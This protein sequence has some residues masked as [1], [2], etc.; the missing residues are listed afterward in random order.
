M[1]S[2]TTLNGRP[3]LKAPEGLGEL[4]RLAWPVVLARLGIMTMGLTDAIVVGRHSAEQLGFH[5]LAW[6]PTSVMLTTS[7]GLLLGVQV[8]TARYIGEGRPE[9]VGGVLRRGLVYAF[10]IGV[11]SMLL[12]ALFG[13]PFLHV[14]GLERPLADGAS[15]PLRVFS[16]SLPFYLVSVALT[17]F[18]EALSRPKPGMVA[19][20]VANIVNLGVNLWL[21]PG[22]SGLPVEGA[23][24]SAWATFAAR[25]ALAVWLAIYVLRLPEARTFGLFAKP[26]DGPRAGAEQRK[27]GYGSGASYFIEVGAFAGMTVVAG[28]LGGIEV[29]AWTVVLNVAAIVFMGPLGLS[30]AT[31]VLVSR[32]YGARDR[33]GVVR[34]GML[35]FG[36]TVAAMLAVCAVVWPGARLIAGAYSSDQALLALAVPALV[37][38]CLFFVADGLQVVAAQALRARGDVWLP[39]VSHLISYTLVMLPLGWAFAHPLGMGVDGIVWSVILASLLSAAILCGRFLMLARRPL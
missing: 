32:A 5:A 19:I 39:T 12:L 22:G 16:L 35:G 2:E 13:P 25:G 28:W 23:T 14:I 11:V 33:R 17:F 27:I 6:A 3:G 31:G 7:V 24:A 37:L 10:W 8:L 18:L 9:A 21:V 34:S 30:S 15:E 20:W 36:V 1:P 38:C 29:A 4:L 26:I